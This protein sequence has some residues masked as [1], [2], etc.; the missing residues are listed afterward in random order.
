ML[1]NRAKPRPKLR[2][3]FSRL[4]TYVMFVSDLSPGTVGERTRGG[5]VGDWSKKAREFGDAVVKSCCV[6]FDNVFLDCLAANI[7]RS[8]RAAFVVMWPAF[9]CID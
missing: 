2:E 8:C 7:R 6:P 3:L 9:P 5:T 1:S 4:R